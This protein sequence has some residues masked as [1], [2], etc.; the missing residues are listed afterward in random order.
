MDES[1]AE[2]LEQQESAVF[3]ETL[4]F[5]RPRQVA[6]TV[7]TVVSRSVRRT[8]TCNFEMAQPSTLDSSQF[9]WANKTVVQLTYLELPRFTAVCLGLVPVFSGRYHGE[10]KNKSL[11]AE[12]TGLLKLS[13]SKPGNKMFFQLNTEERFYLARHMVKVLGAHDGCNSPD[14]TIALLKEVYRSPH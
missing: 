6:L 14:A 13:I 4:K 9:D 7:Q 11:E 1:S 12:F 3:G 5:Y 8:P 10:S 2:S